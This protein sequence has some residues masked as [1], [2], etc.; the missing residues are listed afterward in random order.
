[1]PD[2]KQKTFV[3][4]ARDPELDLTYSTFVSATSAADARQKMRDDFKEW[5]EDDEIL[6]TRLVSGHTIDIR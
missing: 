2:L 5:G 6:H 3:V 1:M 4:I